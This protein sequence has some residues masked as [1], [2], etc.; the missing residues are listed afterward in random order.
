VEGDVEA[1]NLRSATVRQSDE[2]GTAFDGDVQRHLEMVLLLTDERVV[3][4]RKVETLVGIHAV[5]D[6]RPADKQQTTSYSRPRPAFS[7]LRDVTRMAR[8]VLPPGELRYINGH[9][10]I[11][12]V[13]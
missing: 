8:R 5:S 1:V 10:Y 12:G 11:V 2:L 6:H 3:L 13:Q 7:R 9:A 4:R